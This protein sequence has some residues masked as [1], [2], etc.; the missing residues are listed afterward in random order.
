MSALALYSPPA[1]APELRAQVERLIAGPV[2]LPGI[3]ADDPGLVLTPEPEF[4]PG[5][6]AE[7]DAKRAAL[8][9]PMAPR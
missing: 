4:H 6:Q 2:R 5:A 9:Q 1:M 8:A 3:E 7:A